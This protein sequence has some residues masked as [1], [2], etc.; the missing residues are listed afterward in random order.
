MGI[1]ATVIGAV[2]VILVVAAVAPQF[3][4]A[5]ADTNEVLT[6]AN[7]TTGDT[8]ADSLL[9]VFPLMIGITGLFAIVGIVLAAVRFSNR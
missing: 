3:F 2:V 4:S 7:T 9:G 5:L 6:D 1:V 8:T